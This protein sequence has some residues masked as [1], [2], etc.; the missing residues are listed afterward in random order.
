[1]TDDN[2]EKVR[3][4]LEMAE[5]DLE[6]A[7]VMLKGKRFLYVGFMC[8]QVIEKSL[9]ASIWAKQNT[10]PEYIHS[11]ARL[12]NKS[13]LKTDMPEKYMDLLDALQPMNIQARYP[14]EKESVLKSLTEDRCELI[15]KDTEDFYRWINKKLSMR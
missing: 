10:E 7:R 11:L 12:C 8:H 2:T 15:I 1:M 4:W 13:G 9:K 5:Y 6:T 14:T 3:Y